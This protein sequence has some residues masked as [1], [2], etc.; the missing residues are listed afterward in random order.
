VKAPVC[1]EKE[2]VS[3]FGTWWRL[4]RRHG[5]ISKYY[6]TAAHLGHRTEV[7]GQRLLEDGFTGFIASLPFC[8]SGNKFVLLEDAATEAIPVLRRLN[9]SLSLRRFGFDPKPLHVRLVLNS[10]TLR[11]VCHQVFGVSAV[12]IHSTNAPNSSPSIYFSYQKDK[13]A[14]PGNIAD[15]V[16]YIKE[17]Y[18]GK[19]LSRAYR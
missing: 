18:T 10:V 7:R 6:T 15:A 9:V 16:S 13:G 5:V 8:V 17:Y 3:P 11:R 4:V 14:K 1:S 19:Y 12:S 2:V